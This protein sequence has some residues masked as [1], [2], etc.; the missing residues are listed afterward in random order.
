M[1]KLCRLSLPSSPLRGNL[2]HTLSLFSEVVFLWFLF[3]CFS[4]P[5]F[6]ER[7]S[8]I[9]NSTGDMKLETELTGLKWCV[10]ILLVLSWIM[11]PTAQGGGNL[12]DII[13]GWRWSPNWYL[14]CNYLF[15]LFG[16]YVLFIFWGRSSPRAPFPEWKFLCSWRLSY[17]NIFWI[18]KQLFVDMW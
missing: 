8:R 12:P 1:R 15:P 4:W 13:T 7:S 10:V 9:V 18:L 3:R 5:L 14:H 17:F 11:N 16:V 2:Q 6:E